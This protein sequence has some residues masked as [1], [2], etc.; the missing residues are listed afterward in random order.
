[1]PE[2]RDVL[3]NRHCKRIV[4]LKYVTPH[5]TLHEKNQFLKGNKAF[6]YAARAARYNHL[7]AFNPDPCREQCCTLGVDAKGNPRS[8]Q[9]KIF[10]IQDMLNE[11]N[12]HQPS[13]TTG[14]QITHKQNMIIV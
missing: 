5:G 12:R 13:W 4:Y 3:V 11:F 6:I 7:I 14:Q 2:I 9:G 10:R 1:M 8:F